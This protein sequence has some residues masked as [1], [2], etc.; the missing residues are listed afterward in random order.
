MKRSLTMTLTT[1]AAASLALSAAHAQAPQAQD[2]PNR[3]I[4]I[5]V[6]FTAGGAVD[7]IARTMAKHLSDKF[8]QQIY[9]ENRPGASG[10]IGAETVAQSA[11]DGYTLLISASTFVVN[12][13]VSAEHASFDPLKDFSPLGLIAKGPLLFIVHAGVADS[14]QDFVAKARAHPEAFNFATGGY[15]SAGHMAAESFKLRAGLNV[16]VVLYKGTGPAFTDLM[17]GTISGMLDPLVTS[18]PLAQGKTAT[19]LAIAGPARSALAPE[20]P[21]FAEAGFPGFAFYTWYGL[22]GPANLPAN[23]ISTIE[24]ALT[25]IGTSADAQKWF[26]AQGLQYS[27]VGGPPFLDFSRS[28]QSLYADI[29]KK[30]NIKPQ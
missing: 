3:L 5:I 25:E 21:T 15:G 20:V 16:P 22:W 9:V 1:I 12:P 26:E 29:V 19:A 11:P 18:L 17:G 14:V 30:G 6:P 10:N 24:Q 13:V 27:G 2:Y 28:E 8:H 4:R 23:V 7:V